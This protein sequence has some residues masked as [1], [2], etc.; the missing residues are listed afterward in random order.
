MTRTSNT[1]HINNKNN[2]GRISN[3]AT[4]TRSKATGS[5]VMALR[6]TANLVRQVVQL[7]AIVASGPPSWAALAAH[8]SAASLVVDR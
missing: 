5:K 8:S 7:K 3:K 2:M 4:R 6:N 1:G